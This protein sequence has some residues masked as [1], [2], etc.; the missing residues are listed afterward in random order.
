MICY[1]RKATVMHGRTLLSCPESGLLPGGQLQYSL[2]RT[3]GGRFG[4]RG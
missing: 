2:Q 4:T 1:A 3:V